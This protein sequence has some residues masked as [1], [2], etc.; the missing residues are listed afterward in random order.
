MGTVLRNQKVLDKRIQSAAGARAR[1]AAAVEEIGE[2][3]K[4]G[5][6]R[7]DRHRQEL[8][9][10]GKVLADTEATVIGLRA[11]HTEF[12]KKVTAEVINPLAEIGT[13]ARFVKWLVIGVVAGVP[14]LAAFWKGGQV[15]GLWQ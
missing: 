9:N 1:T 5:D 4:Q 8:I 15:I 14:A 10:Q 7:M 3:L 13:I 11:E 6:A 12:Q 2:S